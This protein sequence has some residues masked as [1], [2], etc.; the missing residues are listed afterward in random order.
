MIFFDRILTE[1][2]NDDFR[3]I[4]SI[5]DEEPIFPPILFI[6]RTPDAL[7]L[8]LPAARS[9]TMVWPRCLRSRKLVSHG[10]DS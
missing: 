4:L 8:H 6:L 5:N 3:S 10:V 9:L 7:Q 2:N 1:I